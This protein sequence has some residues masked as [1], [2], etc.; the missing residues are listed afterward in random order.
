MPDM[1]VELLAA[2]LRRDSADLALYT[3]VLAENLTGSL[4]PGTVRVER[5]RRLADR[6]AGR[7][8]TVTALDIALGEQRL[9][10]RIHGGAATG[11]IRHEVRGIVLSRRPAALDEW[12][13]AL[14]R[15]LADA[16]ASNARA[17]EAVERLLT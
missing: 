16:A 7:E 9:S 12:T 4:P 2:A 3:R 1:D 13:G 6:L 11:E 15:A 8:G 10:L 17:R 14:A 5:T